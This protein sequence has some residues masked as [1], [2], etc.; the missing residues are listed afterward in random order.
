MRVQEVDKKEIIKVDHVWK[1][2]NKDKCNKFFA[3]RDI[4]FNIKEGEKIA[5]IGR[6]GSGKS[7]TIKM[8]SGI[9]APTRGEIRVNGLTPHKQ[10]IKNSQQIGV[11]FANKSQLWWDVP[12]IDSYKMLKSLYNIPKDIFEENLKKIGE[13]LDIKN[14]LTIPE[15]KL[16]FGQ[17][18]KCN[19]AAAF[20]HNPK[21]VYLDEPTV[22]VDIET[23]LKIREFINE[24]NK[25]KG[26]TFLITSHDYQDIEAVCDRIILL[27]KGEIILDDKI[28]NVKDKFKKRIKIRVQN[29]DNKKIESLQ[30][31]LDDHMEIN[32]IVK[33][34]AEKYII[35]S[36]QVETPKL[37][38]VVRDF[39]VTLS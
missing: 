15:R 28:K 14:I 35:Q 24:N 13:I 23:K 38:E 9:L 36:I 21:I 25:E 29:I 37:E 8:L 30:Y 22:G 5:Y 16:S 26:T 32:G 19:L 11:V 39:I 20:L 12:V 10:R 7:T 33:S 1:E 4:C 18:T 2:Y 31:E 17:R 6:N 34:L 3:V 27:E